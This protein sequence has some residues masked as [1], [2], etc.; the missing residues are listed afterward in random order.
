MSTDKPRYSRRYLLATFWD[1][2]L[3]F[4]RKEVIDFALDPTESAW[5]AEGI[6]VYLSDGHVVNK[7]YDPD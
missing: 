5:N 7:R 2:A 1:S 6:T 3:G 4:W